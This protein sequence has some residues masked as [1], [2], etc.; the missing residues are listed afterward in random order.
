MFSSAEIDRAKLAF[1]VLDGFH[2]AHIGRIFDRLRYAGDATESELIT[3]PT[4][5]QDRCGLEI[6]QSPSWREAAAHDASIAEAVA[7]AQEERSLDLPSFTLKIER[8]DEYFPLAPS[9]RMF[10]LTPRAERAAEPSAGQGRPELEPAL[11]SRER[12]IF[13]LV[14]TGSTTGAI[15]QALGI[16]KGTVKNNKLRIYRK[17]DVTSER[18]LF[19]KF[20]RQTSAG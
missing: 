1:P 20:G 10:V 2:R 4:L 13:D 5:V 16:S 8:F 12:A 14:M 17:A 18:A 19:Q 3:R 6:Y 11:T 7:S 15:A 9:G